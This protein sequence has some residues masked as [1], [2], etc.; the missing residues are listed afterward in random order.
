MN[1]KIPVS[2]VRGG[3]SRGVFLRIR[4]LPRELSEREALC[5]SLIGSPDPLA[6]DGLGGGASSN[7]K[8]MAVDLP[9]RITAI[10]GADKCPDGIDL[11]TLFAQVDPRS[12]SVDWSGNCG[13]LSAAVS[14]YALDQQLLARSGQRAVVRVWNMNTNSIFEL[15]HDLD[16]GVLPQS[17]DFTIPGVPTPG[18]RI[19]LRF[20]AP[21]GEKTGSVLPCGPMTFL[22]EA[23]IEAS[24]V[25]VTN[26]LVLIRAADVGLKSCGMPE[27]LNKEPALLE[28]LESIRRE[29][30][31]LMGLPQ[32][33]AIPRVTCL[34]PAAGTHEVQTRTTS[35]GVL[36][37]AIPVTGA[38]ALGAA[39]AL[40]GTLLDEFV[41]R[42]PSG[43][44][45]IQQPQGLVTTTAHTH[46]DHLKS[47]G[48]ARTA[49]IIMDGFTYSN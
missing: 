25:D 14:A 31:K 7:S 13:N 34:F 1:N 44:L 19:D 43:D 45:V 10:P 42:A 30:G 37:H 26:P 12:P 35:M 6:V 24:L 8:I 15:E 17:G 28:R 40:G 49:R 21:G 18:P 47:A 32:S 20:L 46:Q 39:A 23:G 2:I 48:I 3:T 5:V 38:L 36:H 11:V 4:D 33:T 29:A 27:E 16:G 9:D 22:P 41:A